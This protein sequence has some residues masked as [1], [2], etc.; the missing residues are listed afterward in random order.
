MVTLAM[1]QTIITAEKNRPLESLLEERF[2]VV[3]RTGV[4]APGTGEDEELR[5]MELCAV[6]RTLVRPGAALPLPVE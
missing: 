6:V 1:M 2:L 5:R 3:L 4:K